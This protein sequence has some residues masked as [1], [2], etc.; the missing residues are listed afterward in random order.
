MKQALKLSKP[1]RKYLKANINQMKIEE[2]TMIKDKFETV[3]NS[4]YLGSMININ[5]SR[6]AKT[7]KT[8]YK[9]LLHNKLIR[10]ETKEN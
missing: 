3:G 1:A 7:I 10:P 4:V 9:R 6:K 5:K 2:N 8:K